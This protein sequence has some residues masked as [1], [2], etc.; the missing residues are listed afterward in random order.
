MLLKIKISSIQNAQKA[1]LNAVHFIL[2]SI[3]SICS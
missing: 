2:S 3:N 1:K